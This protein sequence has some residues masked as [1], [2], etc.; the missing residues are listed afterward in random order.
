MRTS[1]VVV[2]VLLGACKHKEEDTPA[3]PPPVPA[4][5]P[6]LPTLDAAYAE[7][8]PPDAA[9]MPPYAVSRTIFALNQRTDERKGW[10][11]SI[12]VWV[13][14]LRPAPSRSLLHAK[15]SCRANDEIL[16]DVL[17]VTHLERIDPG[18]TTMTN[19]APFYYG[20]L[21]EKPSRCTLTFLYLADGDPTR[22]V[23]TESFCWDGE[24][25]SEGRCP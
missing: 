16:V 8:P 21:V 4:P 12:D 5:T 7:A 15:A 17:D 18:E 9:P 20:P 6:S 23:P 19:V 3:L 2:L 25:V 14:R 11:L 1:A 22:A 13:R 10:W 24:K